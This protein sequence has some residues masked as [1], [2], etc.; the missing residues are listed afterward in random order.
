MNTTIFPPGWL[1]YRLLAVW[2]AQGEVLR[3]P[4]GITSKTHYQVR[5]ASVIDLYLD[6]AKRK[7]IRSKEI[8]PNY[9]YDLGKPEQLTDAAALL[10]TLP[11]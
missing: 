6:L 4:L 10:N 9:W 5:P 3:K 11:K 7:V 8:H 1:L 2:V